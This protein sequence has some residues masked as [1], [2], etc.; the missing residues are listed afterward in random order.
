MFWVAERDVG[1]DWSDLVYAEVVKTT[2]CSLGPQPTTSPT[3]SSQPSISSA[4]TKAPTKGP[5]PTSIY[6]QN[7]CGTS[8]TAANTNCGKSCPYGSDTECDVGQ[9]CYADCT[10]CPAVLVGTLAPT[11]SLEPTGDPVTAAPYAAS[12][13]EPYRGTVNFGYYEE[14]ATYRSGSCNP[15]QPNAIDVDGFGYT[16][17]AFSFAGVSA[18]G[19]I[20]PYNGNSAEYVPKYAS[21][22]SLKTNHPTLKTLIAVGGEFL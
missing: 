10:N 19:L 4:P 18:S 9:I 3:G 6:N 17:L 14:W 21:F 5:K 16:H 7:Y 2:D 13:C 11:E 20:E 12:S 1:G 15:L 22:N 8:W